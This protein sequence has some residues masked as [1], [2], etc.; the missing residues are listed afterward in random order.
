MEMDFT[1]STFIQTCF[2]AIATLLGTILD[3]EFG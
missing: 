2:R 1:N 3:I